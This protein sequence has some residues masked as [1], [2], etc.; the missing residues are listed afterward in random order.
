L[1]CLQYSFV[2]I[3][4]YQLI[5]HLKYVIGREVCPEF[6]K[7]YSKACGDAGRTMSTCRMSINFCG[8]LKNLSE[9][10]YYI[11]QKKPDCK[12]Y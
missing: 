1:K 12:L 10:V 7:S 2:V 6:V 9:F 8:W 11:I 5:R 4:E 3:G